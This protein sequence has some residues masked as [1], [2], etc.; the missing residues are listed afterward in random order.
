VKYII[1][2][3]I[4]FTLGLIGVLN[5][6]QGVFQQAVFP[7]QIGIR[8]ITRDF[9]GGFDFFSRL[10]DIRQENLTLLKKN[11]E[12]Q[13]IIVDLKVAK[14]ENEI[15][16]EQ[17]G[18][19]ES[20]E[21]DRNLIMASVLGNPLDVSGG[22]VLIDRGSKHGV[23]PNDIVILGNH[24]IGVVDNVSKSR[25]VVNLL[26]SPKVSTT[27]V[28]LDSGT[29]GIVTGQHGT[30]LLL[31]RVLPGEELRVGD[32]IVT[33]GKDGLFYPDLFIGEVVEVIVESANPLK[34]ARVQPLVNIGD[35]TKV[36]VVLNK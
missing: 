3:L 20:G 10:S 23:L 29:Q 31:N 18:L 33:S 27:A 4:L 9:Y 22:S 7:L 2:S 12:L 17:L 25:G 26:T 32:M 15:L 30:S 5:P 16:R 14:D 8:E 34:S 21:F 11:Q 1:A 28:D 19:R 24:L 35:L 36:F 13:S 6:I